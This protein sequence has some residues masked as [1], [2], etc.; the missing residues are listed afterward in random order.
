MLILSGTLLVGSLAGI[1]NYYEISEPEQE[2]RYL[3]Q[4][5]KTQELPVFAQKS[6]DWLASVQFA[7]GGWGAGSHSA[8]H[9]RDAR[10]VDVD[11][12]TTAFASL[13]LLRA[14]NTLQSGKYRE[15][16]QKSLNFLLDL[17]EKCPENTERITDISGTQPQ[18]KL[19]QNI[20]A[21]L[22]AK[23]F[24]RIL[25]FTN[26]DKTLEGRVN[27]AIDK[28]LAKIQKSQNAD[29][30]V[31]GGG[32]APVLQDAMVTEVLETNYNMGRD[33][34][35]K[36][37]ERAREN[38][39]QNVSSSGEVRSDKGAGVSLYTVASSQRATAQEAK[40]AKDALE[41]A[42]K[43][44]KIAKDALVNAEN[45]RRSG[46]SEEEAKKLADAYTQNEVT[47]QKMQDDQVLAGFGN[48]GGEEFLSFMMTSESLVITGGDAWTKWK[49]KM[50]NM[51]QQIQNQDGSWNGHHCITSPVFCTAAVILSLT[52]ENDRDILM[53]DK[54]QKK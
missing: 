54:D 16:L 52:A 31:R 53:K 4:T 32:W 43:T 12:G 25:P 40:K 7:N 8:Q 47:I 20:D 15:N 26:H 10:Q 11:P 29:G 21:S 36:A 30:S 13:A 22:C 44:G 24:T 37:L 33:V 28:C 2:V 19:G 49:A 39:K 9:I 35:K 50:H 17:V 6:I 18:V 45:L 51:L 5:L 23:F 34:D 48:N 46:Y 42:Q 1:Q 14:G 41:E 3:K 38:Q 27:R